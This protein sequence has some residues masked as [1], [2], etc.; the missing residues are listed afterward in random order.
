MKTSGFR[1][2]AKRPELAKPT[3]SLLNT[4]KTLASDKNTKL[5]IISGRDRHS[6]ESWFKGIDIEF[7]AEHGVWI[8]EQ[9]DEDWRMFKSI[10]NYDSTEPILTYDIKLR[11]IDNVNLKEVEDEI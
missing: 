2:F 11:L 4:V 9:E 3:E 6:L 1:S 10:N 7:A 5:V 8:K